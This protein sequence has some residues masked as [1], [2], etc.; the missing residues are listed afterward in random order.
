[1]LRTLAIE[2]RRTHPDLVVAALHP[3]TVATRLSAPFAGGR[4]IIAPDAAHLLDVID[5]LRPEDSGGFFAWD[6]SAIP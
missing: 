6:G 4:E 1:M 3:G 2:A 5:A